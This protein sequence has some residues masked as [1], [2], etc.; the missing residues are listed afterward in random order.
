[1]TAH[2]SDWHLWVTGHFPRIAR[3]EFPE[4]VEDPY[5]VLEEF[6]LQGIVADL[7]SFLQKGVTDTA[8]RFD[9]PYEPEALALLQLTSYRDWW[10]NR[11]KTQ[12]R[13]RIRKAQKCE[14][15][16]RLVPFDRTLMGQIK[17]LYDEHPLR[18]GQPLSYHGQSLDTLWQE[19][20]RFLERS[21]FIG[22]FHREELIGFAKVVHDQGVS[23]IV[24]LIA[25]LGHKDKAP[26]NALLAKVVELCSERQ[27]PYLTYSTWGRRGLGEFKRNHAFVPVTLPRYYVPLNLKGKL[28]VRLRMHKH[29]TELLPCHWVDLAAEL[30][31]KLYHWRTA[32]R[33]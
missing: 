5:P 10:E 22:A 16:L 31:G 32:L 9:F 28:A 23:H 21:D 19:H 25:R 15:E 14:V 24:K 20:A 33:K 17:E 26:S 27:V 11:I 18:Q 7:F 6:R 30:R 12:E 2:L 8:P 4:W 1:M 13:N 29:L 3:L